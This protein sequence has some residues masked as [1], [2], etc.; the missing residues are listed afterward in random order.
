MRITEINITK[1]NSLKR[2]SNMEQRGKQNIG[3]ET[4]TLEPIPQTNNQTNYLKN[5]S[6]HEDNCFIQSLFLAIDE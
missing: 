4:I 1:R 3:S 5:A 2:N 6:F